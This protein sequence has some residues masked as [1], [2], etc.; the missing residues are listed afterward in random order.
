[1]SSNPL[2]AFQYG[3]TDLRDLIVLSTWA[4]LGEEVT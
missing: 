2:P 1:M 4:R 3:L